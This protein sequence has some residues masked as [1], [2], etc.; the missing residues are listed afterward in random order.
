VRRLFAGRFSITYEA[1][2]Q[3]HKMPV[4]LEVFPH[5]HPRYS[6]EH[7]VRLLKG[8]ALAARLRH[9][10]VVGI[11]DLGRREGYDYVVRELVG[12]DSVRALLEK[13]GKLA[14]NVALPIAEDVLRA[15][16]EAERL[17]LRHG[18]ISP[19]TI[20]LDYDG[21]AKLEH[22]GRPLERDELLEF[23][24]T[25]RGSLVGPCFY[26][27][28][29]QVEDGE[30]GDIRTDLFSLGVS[31]HEM[32]SGRVPFDGES[33]EDILSARLDAAP[34]P[35]R[36]LDP[37]IPA[38]VS[39]FV[40][41]LTSA[42]PAGRP[43]TACEALERL[44]EVALELSRRRSVARAPR[45]KPAAGDKGRGRLQA[46][47]WTALAFALLAAAAVPLYRLATERGRRELEQDAAREAGSRAMRG[48]VL[49]VLEPAAGP[50][51]QPLPEHRR[52]ALLLLAALQ[53]S[54]LEGLA[55]ID[56]FRSEELC[57]SSGGLEGAVR[58]AGPEYVLRITHAPGLN[59]LKWEVSL[60]ALQGQRRNVR[61]EAATDPDGADA[62]LA[63]GAA[64]DEVLA[65]AAQWVGAGNYEPL[66]AGPAADALS[67]IRLWELLGEAWRQERMGRFSEAVRVLSEA[68]ARWPDAE[69]LGVLEA[70][71]EAADSWER[72]G[73]MTP[74]AHPPQ[75]G[76]LWG[77]LSLLAGFLASVAEGD[78][79]A[80]HSALGEYLASCPRS[81]RGHLLL[82]MWRVQNGAPA[83]EAL[84]AFRRA[85]EL[86]PGYL[87]P[88][89]AAARVIAAR[90]PEGLGAFLEGYK[91][92]APGEDKAEALR[93]FCEQ[94]VR[95]P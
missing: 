52:H 29:E 41:G 44:R 12:A 35:L 89:R 70:L 5:E 22:F 16:C 58:A 59:R 47:L 10:G 51:G 68:T 27:A 8:V 56:P 94:L 23:V 93:A 54:R 30:A 64:V 15:L 82:G 28:P 92:L 76:A 84:A 25:P 79:A 1:V 13:R 69:F 71:Y 24:P 57:A 37:D 4:L 2:Q 9:P 17:G 63:L 61:R 42:D 49:L 83:D 38:E 90:S 50:G 95:E 67:H 72:R 45:L 73:R 87:P 20:L 85:M 65:G 48:G 91:R 46:A 86:D 33:A 75:G 32:L 6:E 19:D 78:R 40:E 55:L 88:A 21:R 80:A 53:V 18:R 3:R 34:A 60:A 7:V 11:L 14:L 39:D 43:R 62:P 81:P 77:E 74:S 66:M 36:A 31:L 26:V